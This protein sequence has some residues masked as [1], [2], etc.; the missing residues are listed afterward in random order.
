[1]GN[2]ASNVEEMAGY[3]G[4]AMLLNDIGE[5]ATRWSPA[6]LPEEDCFY[7]ASYFSCILF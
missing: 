6:L 1:M 5:M 3:E 7:F 2:S 4:L